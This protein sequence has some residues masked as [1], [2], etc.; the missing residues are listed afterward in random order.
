MDKVTIASSSLK[1][2]VDEILIK[3]NYYVEKYK[4]KTITCGG[5]V[6]CNS[7]L[8]KELK[9]LPYKVLLTDKKFCN[10]NA[11]MIGVYVLECL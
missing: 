9:Q 1:W 2:V 3:L 7:L 8:R 11:A 5:G 10:D 4:I 6:C